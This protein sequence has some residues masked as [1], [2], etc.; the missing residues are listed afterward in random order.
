MNQGDCG[1]R[2]DC[3]ADRQ[4]GTRILLVVFILVSFG[5]RMYRIEAKSI[6]WDESLSLYRAQRDLPYV[7][8][9]R[10]D[11]PGAETTDLHP[12]LYFVLLHG[13]IRIAGETDLALRFLSVCFAVLIVPL[14]YVVGRRWWGSGTGL[15]AAFIGAVSPFYLW[16]AQEA[17]M[18]T[19]VTCLALFSAYSLWRAMENPGRRWYAAYLVATAAMLYT[20]Y[21]AFLILAFEALFWLLWSLRHRRLRVPWL[22]VLVLGVSTPLLIFAAYRLLS[23]PE[24]GRAFVPLLSILGDTL[25]S[26]A[27][28]V[29]V[30]MR[31]VYLLDLLFLAVFAL[32]VWF[33]GSDRRTM[34]PQ[35]RLFLLGYVLVPVL[36]LYLSS[37]VKP[38]YMG[39]RYVMISSP[40]F[41]LGVAAGLNALLSR[42]V[43][44][45][46]A[47]VFVLIGLALFAGIAYSTYNY[48]F[49]EHYGTK[50][51]H[52]SSARLVELHGRPGD[53]VVVDAP[54]NLPAFWHYFGGALPAVGLPRTAL[55]GR[56]DPGVVSREV[57]EAVAGYERVWLIQC[58]TM[59]S[60]PDQ[61]VRRWLETNAFKLDQRTFRS[62]GSDAAVYLYQ[63]ES[64]VMEDEPAVQRKA[65]AE[66]GQ[67]LALLGY[68]LPQETLSAG[69]WTEL[70]LY[71][72]AESKPQLD[73]KV[74]VQMVD[75][76]GNLWG[77]RDRV[78]F[79]FLPT[80]A[81]PVGSPLRQEHELF[82]PVGTPPGQYRLELRV[83]GRDD[84]KLLP[85]R[86]ET[87]RSVDGQALAL[88]E[89]EI[90]G[91]S[92]GA[93][94][95]DLELVHRVDAA[96]GGRM[97]LLG[98]NLSAHKIDAGGV[99]KLNLHWLA[100]REME[101][102]YCLE[103][104]L[105]D[106][107][108][109]LVGQLVGSPSRATHP[110]TA[111]RPGEIVR[112]QPV[113]QLP[114]ALEPSA[115]HLMRL[116]VRDPLT[117]WALPVWKAG[118]PWVEVCLDLES[119]EVRDHGKGGTPVQ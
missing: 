111:W 105:A 77:Q 62:Y 89:R 94:Q 79:Y 114:E 68:D 46:I 70:T 16:Y 30:Q 117:G 9:N 98:Y 93:S 101:T 48:L 100:L 99:L 69:E 71:W 72:R 50:E 66:F 116:V 6:W 83:Y 60:D 73:Y 81:W 37:L 2:G 4:H 54:E 21:F 55:G 92:A 29:S 44:R 20:H 34:S 25:N 42:K 119:V 11:F 38:F 85:L 7:L 57:D 14:L 17:R 86:S 5:L 58:R 112:G 27:L 74:S 45:T 87:P 23:G 1:S 104:W 113:F 75:D 31:E 3:A 90:S 109:Q 12:P 97:K 84:G 13:F 47:A 102:D 41:Y 88:G 32:G 10:I 108:G 65:D 115:H 15:W 103:L 39:S 40:A 52:R 18:Y 82:I 19:M 24:M 76:E 61:L 56:P 22:F 110:T 106:A 53:L 78:P 35:K 118:R 95:D 63:L 64:P 67:V 26:F 8:S 51:D 96:Y 80:T 28:G 43:N 91:P 33:S 36:G 107:R 59:F 49:D